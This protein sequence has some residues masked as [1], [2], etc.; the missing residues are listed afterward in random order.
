M[1]DRVPTFRLYQ[2][3]HCQAQVS[4]RGE[5]GECSSRLHEAITALAPSKKGK[6]KHQPAQ[7]EQE[8]EQKKAGASAGAVAP[9]LNIPSLAALELLLHQQQQQQ[10]S[11]SSPATPTTNQDEEVLLVE[12][13]GQACKQC[14][15]LNPLFES[16]P[17]VYRDRR[18]RFGRAD[19]THFPTLVI[20]PPAPTAFVGLDRS[21]DIEAR[22]DGCPRCGGGGF[23]P[24]AECAG[25]G[26]IVR[27]VNGHSVA[28]VCMA[29]VGH[30][31]VPCPQ[32]GGKC[33]LC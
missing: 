28:D 3:G 10:S 14:I 22:L 12:F 11:S 1:I 15:A 6:P 33:Y 9:I 21:Q 27:S 17:F 32:C 23:V 16:L 7:E 5:V 19:V 30:R 31:K 26:H 2:H 24:C 29:C 20:P 25:Q 13:Y 18:L 4:G 8:E